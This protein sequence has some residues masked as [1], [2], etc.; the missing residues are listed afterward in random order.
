MNIK[1]E[2]SKI[3]NK[4]YISNADILLEELMMFFKKCLKLKR[5]SQDSQQN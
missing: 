5:S 4:Y 3:L 2:L 1:V